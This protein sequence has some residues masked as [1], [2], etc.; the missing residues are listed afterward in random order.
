MAYLDT[1]TGAN[2]IPELWAQP[3]YKYYEAALKLRGSVDD[4]SS[5]VKGSGDTVHI[6]KIQMD[7]TNDKSASTAVTFSIAGTEGKVDLSINKHKYLANIFE[8]IALVQ[9]NSELISKY[10]RMMGESLARGV[11]DDIWAELDGFNGSVSLGTDNTFAVGDLESILN[12]LYSYDIDPNTC[13]IALNNQLVADFMNPSTGI[14]SYFIRKDAGGDGT[15][16]RSGAVGLIYGMNV[17][18]SRSISSSTSTDAIVGAVYPKEACVFAAQQDVRVQAQYDVEYL[19]TKVVTD[20]IY[21]AKLIDESGHNM[22]LNLKN[23]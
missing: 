12:T 2:F 11:E 23:P 9:A 8:D 4:Y 1:T 14:A 20:M 13:S 18:Y 5:M 10:T 21:G 19:G 22:G 17:F 7:G 6:P 15:E 3:I 16:L